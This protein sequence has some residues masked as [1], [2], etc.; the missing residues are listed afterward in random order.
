MGLGAEQSRASLTEQKR[1]HASGEC[2]I[3]CAA[4]STPCALWSA[5]R[6]I[7]WAAVPLSPLHASI[8]ALGTQL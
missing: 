8:T 6:A 7:G 4:L 5:L 2:W 3:A 1:D